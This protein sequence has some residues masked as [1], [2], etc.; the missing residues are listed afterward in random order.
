LDIEK[1]IDIHKN[2]PTYVSLFVAACALS[3][4][5][6]QGIESKKRNHLLVIPHL[7]I[8]IVSEEP[9]TEKGGISIINDGI[10]PAVI[11]TIKLSRKGE[12]IIDDNE[13][14]YIHT[15]WLKLHE[16]FWPGN[17]EIKVSYLYPRPGG[18]LQPEKR[19]FA[20]EVPSEQL[21]EP[22]VWCKLS[23]VTLEITYSDVYG[24]R[25]QSEFD[26]PTHL[27]FAECSGGEVRKS[28][29]F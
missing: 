15:K 4:S 25:F 5:I 24:N 16:I 9:G 13:S 18:Y 28:A 10:G 2:I 11:N 1:K 29:K 20:L 27:Y 14:N 3:I 7:Y 19:I 17:E 22:D 26:A 12:V 6:W 8:T 21:K 23:D